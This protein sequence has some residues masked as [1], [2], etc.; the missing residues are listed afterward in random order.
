MVITLKTID[1][2]DTTLRDGAQGQSVLFTDDDK[3]GIIDAL[4]KLS[5]SYIEVG[6]PGA[7]KKDFEF[8]K[9]ISKKN[10]KHSKLVAFGSTRRKDKTVFLDENITALLDCGLPIISIFG[11]SW[12]MHVR[13]VLKTS[14]K[15]NLNMIFDTISHLVSKGREVFYDAEHFFDGYKNNREY[16]I[17]TLEAAYRAGASHLILCDTNGGSFPDEI[18]EATKEVITLFPDC[19]IG[20]HCHNDI[21]CAV[22]NSLEAVRAGAIQVQGTFIGIGERCGNTKLYA[23]IPSLELKMGYSCLSEGKMKR[24]TQTAHRLSDIINISLPSQTPYVGLNAFSHKGG[25]HVDGMLKSQRS[26]EHIDPKEVG[27]NRNILISSMSGRAA[28]AAK[29]SEFLDGIS[30]DSPS[31]SVIVD[32]VSALEKKG[33]VFESDATFELLVRREL[34]LMPRFFELENFKIIGEQF[35]RDEERPASAIIKIRVDDRTKLT[36]AEGNGPVNALDNALRKALEVFY[37][38]LKTV[39]LVDFKVRVTEDNTTTSA[40][41]RVIIESSDGENNWT[42]VGISHDVIN[43]SFIALV[44]S[45]EYKLMR[46]SI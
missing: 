19:K 9:R 13:E 45:F 29:M 5:I 33:F 25:M 6:N 31:V 12:D 30:K 7:D 3:L 17:T 39:K 22:A 38:T 20:I 27:N 16:A 37:P 36:A 32:R 41:V 14:E 35:S 1:I 23:I 28:I 43:A 15:E 10:L 8:I 11:K 4:D 2:F 42:T 40:K 18:Y 24:L 44:D 46:D 26:F 34:S 21:G